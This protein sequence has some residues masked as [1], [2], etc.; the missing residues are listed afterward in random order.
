M[1]DGSS[2]KVD[3][4]SSGELVASMLDGGLPPAP[5]R[6]GDAAVPPTDAAPVSSP[7]VD[8]AP[9]LM[10]PPPPPPP[11]PP[12]DA[13][14]SPDLPRSRKALLLIGND[15][16]QSGD[17]E[18]R[19]KLA[20]LGFSVTFKP[21]RSDQE[22]MAVGDMIRGYAL[23]VLSSTL[24]QGTGLPKQVRE[25]PVPIICLKPEF[26]DNLEL[27]LAQKGQDDHETQIAI[28]APMHPMAGGRSGNVT[29]FDRPTVL[30]W[31]QPYPGIP[32]VATAMGQAQNA[33]IF[34]LPAGAATPSGTAPARR[35]A[36]L[37]LD[38]G[39]EHLNTTGWALFAAAVGWATE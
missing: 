10:P 16:L 38:E 6:A 8:A 7:P 4:S 32:A 20:A 37:M 14:A 2:A 9:S 30:G 39:V 27:G 29:I 23:L 18:L 31:G 34:G 22:A 5:Q 36:W 12:V 1:R 25:Y 21:A 35:V 3:G 17:K 11:P 15:E 19:D 24:P 13:S 33:I 26:V 28:V